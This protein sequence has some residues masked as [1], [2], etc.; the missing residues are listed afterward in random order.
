[1]EE[2]ASAQHCERAGG[3][4]AEEVH[5]GPP[6]HRR[7]RAHVGLEEAH[8]RRRAARPQ[9]GDPERDDAQP[10]ASGVGVERQLARDQRPQ[11]VGV[12]GP[13]REQHVAP[14][15]PLLPRLRG[16]QPGAVRRV[17]QRRSLGAGLPGQPPHEPLG[18][19]QHPR[20]LAPGA[21][22]RSR[23]WSA[24][25]SARR[26]S[27]R[28]PPRSSGR[29]RAAARSCWCAARRGSA[30]PR[31]C[32]RCASGRRC[33]STSGAAS[34][35]PCPSRSARCATSP[36]SARLPVPEL[37]GDDRRALARALQAALT[38]RRPGRRRARGRPLGRPGHAGRGAPARPARRR[39]RAGAGGHA[40]RRRARANPPLALLSATWPTAVVR[41]APRPLSRDAVASSPAR[42]RRRRGGRAGHRRQPV[43][44]RR[45]ARR[46]RC[47]C[48]PRSA[49]PR[50]RA[51]RGSSRTRAAS[52]RSPPS[53]AQRVAPELLA[54]LAPGQRRPP[55]RRRSRSGVL[56]DDGA[57]LGFRHELTRQA[58]SQRCPRRAGRRCTPAWPTPSPPAREPTTPGSPITPR[59]PGRGDGGAARRAGRRGGRARRRAARGRPAARPRAAPRRRP[60]AACR[61]AD[62]LCAGHELRGAPAR[63]CPRAPPPRPWRSPTRRGDRRAGGRARAVLSAAL[64]SLDRLE[65]ARDAAAEAV[66][67]LEAAGDPAELARAHAAACGSSRSRSTRRR[68][69]LARPGALARGR[70]G[71]AGGGADRRR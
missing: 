67:L 59:P 9:P 6:V 17:V 36:P 39:R 41:V 23:P 8:Q 16:E 26:T 66:A 57:T 61:P 70:G 22:V 46:G 38:R 24:C 37:A 2:A 51:W 49:R 13:V 29:G 55:S 3:V 52:S 12:H 14:R 69:S 53:P 7:V 1:M 33:R 5:P 18:A 47:R 28:W 45:G 60:D 21:G 62:P 4:Q 40:A 31:C 56:T 71:R 27:P 10:G 34:R 44:R 43:P 58:V 15:L 35:C 64:W 50:W 19:V 48:R 63:R 65:E 32:A 11:H 68:R 42:R 25:S 54:E 20:I 30:R